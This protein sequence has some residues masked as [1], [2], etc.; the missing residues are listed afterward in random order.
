MLSNLPTKP[1]CH[2]QPQPLFAQENMAFSLLLKRLIAAPQEAA[3]S[4]HNTFKI[5][6][7]F[8]KPAFLSRDDLRTSLKADSSST[9][10]P[11]SSG[12]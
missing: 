4:A 7:Y 3:F 8:T 1:N 11:L 6:L 2:L 5:G 9:R 10:A 12:I